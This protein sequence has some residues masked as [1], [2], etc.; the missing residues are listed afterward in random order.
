M[1][2]EVRGK[3]TTHQNGVRFLFAKVSYTSGTPT[4]VE[5]ANDFTITDNGTGDFTLTVREPGQRA[6]VVVGCAVE[7]DTDQYFA[8]PLEATNITSARFTVWTDAGVA[9]DPDGGLVHVTL[10]CFDQSSEN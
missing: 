1:G 8:T 6:M 9:A 7:D 10:V 5:G 4:L 2:F 3:P